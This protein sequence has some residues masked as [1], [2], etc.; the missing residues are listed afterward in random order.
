MGQLLETL[1]SEAAV[2]VHVEVA[3]PDARLTLPEHPRTTVEWHDL[4]PGA[5]PG[6][7]LLAAVR[8]ENLGPTTRVWGAGE[9][10]GVQ[11]LRRH[12]FEERGVPRTQTSVRGYWKRGRAGDGEN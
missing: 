5:S 11:R 9:A 6:D 8:A 4:P 3:D 1:P 7:A 12:L 10:A 2:R